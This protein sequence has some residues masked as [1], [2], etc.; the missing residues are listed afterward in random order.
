MICP[1]CTQSVTYKERSYKTCSN[2]KKEFAFEP[3]SHSLLI[4]D[5]YFSNVVKKLS[6][7]GKLFYTSEQLQFA[8]SRKKIK[9][10]SNIVGLIII[11]TITT[12]I[13]LIISAA[14]LPDPPKAN[15]L[16]ILLFFLIPVAVFFVWVI[17]IGGKI[18]RNQTHICLPQSRSDFNDSVLYRWK[19][20]YGKF[21][22]KLIMEKPQSLSSNYNLRGILFCETEDTANFILAN[23]LNIKFGLTVVNDLNSKLPDSLPI[24]VLHDAT[25]EGIELLEKVK[26]HFGNQRKIIDLGLKPQ[27]V[28]NSK[29]MQFRQRNYGKTDFSSLNSAEIKWLRQGFYT[30][31]FVLRPTQLIKYLDKQFE[32][33]G[34]QIPV[35][36]VEEKAEAI[37]FMTWAGE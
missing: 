22:Q 11:A 37:G 35:E 2:C 3:K 30:P 33:K 9:N 18:I 25:S 19:E 14:L 6:Y 29:L 21:P 36:N 15:S 5:K 28:M 23:Q 8:V 12:I 27:S 13:A 4:S 10:G 31:L 32:Q 7:D 24:Y 34:N 1:H 16:R 26:T 20:I 17:V